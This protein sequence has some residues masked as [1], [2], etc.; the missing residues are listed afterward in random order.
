MR[1]ARAHH[2]TDVHAA[3]PS[4]SDDSDESATESE[5]EDPTSADSG[6]TDDEADYYARH[7]DFV[8]SLARVRGVVE[9]AWACGVAKL[10]QAGVCARSGVGAALLLP[11]LPVLEVVLSIPLCAA[12]PALHRPRCACFPTRSLVTSV[13]TP[14]IAA[15]LRCVMDRSPSGRSSRSPHMLLHECDAW[16]LMGVF[17]PASAPL[18]P[19]A[20]ARLMTDPQSTI[21]EYYPTDIQRFMLA[22]AVLPSRCHPLTPRRRA[23]AAVC[24][25][26]ATAG[27][28][29]AAAELAVGGGAAAERIR[30][31]QAVRPGRPRAGQVHKLKPSQFVISCRSQLQGLSSDEAAP[32]TAPSSESGRER[33]MPLFGCIKAV[34]CESGRDTSSV[35]AEFI[36]PV[37][38]A[39]F[40]FPAR[41]LGGSTTTSCCPHSCMHA[42]GKSK[43]N[44]RKR[45]KHQQAS[46]ASGSDSQSDTEGRRKPVPLKGS[47]RTAS[48]LCAHATQPRL[49]LRHQ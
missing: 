21:A 41:R 23:D 43:P 29:G 8:P 48:A 15:P 12:H 13:Q 45:A 31:G 18:L 32:L 35:V 47:R 17:P 37:F 49:Q 1:R 27:G 44:K 16:Q 30:R 33:T 4:S 9:V 7:F 42:L 3:E 39:G 38:A 34:A 28:T 5:N 36:D 6:L 19:P 25:R 22:G 24:G 14:L 10:M 40:E 20:W 11:G 26:G 2:R 46:N